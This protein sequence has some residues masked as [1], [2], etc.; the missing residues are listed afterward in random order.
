V[1]FFRFTVHGGDPLVPDGKRGFFTTRHAFAASKEEAARKLLARLTAEFT[2]GV[3][4][5]IWKS[6]AP[7]FT[8]ES[9]RRIGLHQ[10]YA[11][12]NKGSTFYDERE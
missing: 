12:P 9:V 3:S 4:A 8:I 1:P 7:E 2:R 6:E 5:H 11:A 10:L